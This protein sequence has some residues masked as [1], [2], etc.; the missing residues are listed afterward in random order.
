MK[1]IVQNISRKILKMLVVFVVTF[2]V[3]LGT[4]IK[5]QGKNYNQHVKKK[6]KLVV[7]ATYRYAP[8]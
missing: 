3:D 7:I 4:F 6:K 2:S 1:K 5:T 8:V